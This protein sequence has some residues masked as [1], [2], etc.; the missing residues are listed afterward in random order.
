MAL[1]TNSR[2]GVMRTTIISVMVTLCSLATSALLADEPESARQL[3]E[4]LRSLDETATTERSNVTVI[5]T[6]GFSGQQ[7]NGRRVVPL[8]DVAER[9]G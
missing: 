1:Q 2:K 9:Y 6:S 7:C 4:R 5:T 8:K 3:R